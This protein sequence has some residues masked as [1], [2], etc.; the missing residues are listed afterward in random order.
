[1]ATSTLQRHDIAASATGFVGLLITAESLLQPHVFSGGAATAGAGGGALVL[2]ASIVSWV[3]AH[4]HVSAATAAAISSD[5][6]KSYPVVKQVVADA[7]PLVKRFPGVERD[8]EYLKLE[9]EKIFTKANTA[10]G[11]NADAIAREVETQV[12]AKF[13]SILGAAP[14]AAPVVAAPVAPVNPA[15]VSVAAGITLPTTV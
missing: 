3:F 13:A 7:A 4:V 15:P 1:M 11:G 14:V 5:V 2:V 6:T 12:R 8:V 9:L 10:T